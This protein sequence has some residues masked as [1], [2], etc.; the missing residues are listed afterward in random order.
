MSKA[1]KAG[2]PSKEGDRIKAGGPAQAG[3]QVS[4]R[5]PDKTRDQATTRDSAT[6]RNQVTTR[7]SATARDQAIAAYLESDPDF[8]VRHPDLT[9][10]LRLPHGPAG[11][12]SLV[13]HQ[14]NLLRNQ[15]ENDRQV[16]A[17]LIARARDYEALAARIHGLMIQLIAAPNRPALEALLQD[18]LRRE[19]ETEAVALFFD[20]QPVTATS[21]EPPGEL[22]GR[23][24]SRAR[25]GPL[26]AGQA[27]RLFAAAAEG[28]RSAALIPLW[29]PHQHGLLAIGSRDP[30]RFRPDM[31][32]DHLNRLGELVS[33]CLTAQERQ[34]PDH[35]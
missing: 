7:D 28:I 10:R 2:G 4:A 13:E 19:F 15:I 12:L 21:P 26:D 35:G 6:A 34:G 9:A 3:D 16:L 22:A 32:T 23:G 5:G 18:S 27:R 31:G 1:T 29:G 33:A 14:L 8:F 17:Q 11:T 30:E 20:D 25:C 24:D